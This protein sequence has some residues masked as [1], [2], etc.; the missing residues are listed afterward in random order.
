MSVEET[1]VGGVASDELPM[2]KKQLFASVT[3]GQK[4]TF[5]I[6]DGDPIIGY[7]AGLDDERMFVLEPIGHDRLEFR[8][9]FIDRRSGGTPVFE[10]HSDR[11]YKDEPA[12]EAMDEIIGR[13][14]QWIAKN[15]MKHRDRS[16]RPARFPRQERVAP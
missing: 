5:D 6:F 16:P 11:A 4:I 13:F 3:S 1:P 12:R 9:R 14:R 15:V 10:I 8:K 7:L 2:T